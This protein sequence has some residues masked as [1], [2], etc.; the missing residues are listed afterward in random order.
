MAVRNTKSIELE[1]EELIKLKK[2]ANTGDLKHS[3]FDKPKNSLY[4]GN[5]SS[6]FTSE[7]CILY[8]FSQTVLRFK[9][10]VKFRR[11]QL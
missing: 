2:S 11:S 9:R 5:I 1:F 8:V 4:D 6:L 7:H 3:S 10:A